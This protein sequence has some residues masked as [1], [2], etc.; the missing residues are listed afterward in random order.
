[1]ITPQ[2]VPEGMRVGHDVSIDLTLDAGVP[3]DG[4]NSR[5]QEVDV[6]RPNDHRGHIRL[7]D[8]AT[9]PNNDFILRYDVAGQKISDALLTH[10][11]ANGGFF[12]LI[13]QPP[14][15]V[16]VE[17]VTP[18]ELVFVLDTSGSMEGFPLEKAK[19]TMKLALEGLYPQDT[20]NLITFAGDTHILFD[21]PVPATPENL[22]KAKKFLSGRRGD[23]GTEMMKAIRAALAPSDS[24]DHVR[25]VCFMTDCHVGDATGILR[26][27]RT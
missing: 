5:M 24:Q 3:I 15:R 11:T 23:G 27:D 9:I 8:Q 13:L 22:S 2:P 20:F 1:R 26:Q 21:R 19:E 4:L 12:T 25:V 14:E 7:K 17:D 6:E 18:K 16:T 10:S